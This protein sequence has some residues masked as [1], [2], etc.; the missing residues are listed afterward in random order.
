MRRR[1]KQTAGQREPLP[2]FDAWPPPALS[3][4][5]LA[6]LERID[7]EATAPDGPCCDPPTLPDPQHLGDDLPF[8]ALWERFRGA[9]PDGQ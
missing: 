2:L 5:S 8:G 1:R 9:R 6:E 7:R 3:L 4:P